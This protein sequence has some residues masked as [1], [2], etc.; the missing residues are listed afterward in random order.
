MKKI[1]I[2]AVQYINSQIVDADEFESMAD[3]L[4]QVE[5]RNHEDRSVGYESSWSVYLVDGQDWFLM[6]NYVHSGARY[7]FLQWLST[8]WQGKAT[9]WNRSEF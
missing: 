3:A 2:I 1:R 8:E 4:G 7:D 5:E 6:T 9:E